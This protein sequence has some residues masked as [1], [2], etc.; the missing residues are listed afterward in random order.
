MAAVEGVGVSP[1]WRRGRRGPQGRHR[2][3]RVVGGKYNLEATGKTNP[4][5]MTSKAGPTDGQN[6]AAPP[7]SSTTSADLEPAW[8]RKKVVQIWVS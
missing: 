1:A 8:R 6:K 3:G 2:G 7:V 5:V 4:L